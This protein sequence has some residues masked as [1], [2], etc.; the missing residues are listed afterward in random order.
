MSLSGAR[1]LDPKIGKVSGF[2]HGVTSE[3]GSPDL[4]LDC[5]E[6]GSTPGKC[7]PSSFRCKEFGVGEDQ[8]I[9]EC[10]PRLA[11]QDFAQDIY[12]GA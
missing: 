11:N 10:L 1:F 9:G 5:G 4:K 12:F 6:C 8:N 3:V 7:L 2:D